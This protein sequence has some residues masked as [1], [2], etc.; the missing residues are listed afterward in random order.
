MGKG[1]S[2]GG[3]GVQESVV[4][5]T[6]LPEYAQPFYEELLGRT[7]YESTRP[8]EAFPGQRLADF[9]EF[10][11]LGM[12]GMADIAAR[13][14]PEQIGFAS[15]I[16]AQVGYQPVGAGADIAA[17]FTP[18]M[19]FS[20]YTAGDIGSGYTAGGLGQGYQ[21]GQRGS[22]FQETAFDPSYQAGTLD[23][24]FQAQTLSPTY[25]AGQFD[26]AYEATE[27][28]SAFDVGPI[29]SAYQAGQFDPA[30]QARDIQSQYTGQ[31]DLGPGFQA[32]TIADPATLQAYMNPYQQLVTDI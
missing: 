22:R 29:A 6:N 12:E 8:Y 27:R 26:P 25:Q 18:P 7:V 13:G 28:A 2:G 4:T 21:A 24:G 20:G 32:G 31:V 11:Q 3:G 30:Y 15:D 1:S 23:Q 5:Q 19:Q 10:E 14:A 16:A 17:G 9:T